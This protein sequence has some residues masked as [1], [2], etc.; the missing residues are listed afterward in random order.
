M[1]DVAFEMNLETFPQGQAGWGR[2]WRWRAVQA[3]TGV[4][5]TSRGWCCWKQRAQ[6]WDSWGRRLTKYHVEGPR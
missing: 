5:C 1:K 3:G 6:V 4:G 2:L